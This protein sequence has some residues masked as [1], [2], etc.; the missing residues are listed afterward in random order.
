MALADLDEITRLVALMSAHDLE[1]IEVERDG[2]RV[3]IKRRVFPEIAQPSGD[4]DAQ[5]DTVARAPADEG[6][7]VRVRVVQAPI[8]GTV[9]RAPKPGAAPFVELGS[10]VRKGQV[11][12]LIEAMKLMNEIDAEDDGEVDEIFVENEQAVQY[13]DRLFAIKTG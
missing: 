3:R 7:A 11:L 8:V 9:Y 6:P 4:D 13:G 2:A 5:G 1:E 10:R 12:C